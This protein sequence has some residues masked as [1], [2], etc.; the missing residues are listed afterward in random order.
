MRRPRPVALVILDGWGLDA[1]TEHNAVALARTPNVDGW[2]RSFPHCT[3]A[4]AGEA[5][6]LLE[7]QIGNSNVGHLNLGAGRIV[8]QDLTRIHRTIRTG[9]FYENP[10]L[11]AAVDRCAK[12]ASRAGGGSASGSPVL[13]LMG[14]VSDGGV[15][16]HIEHL[17]ALIDLAARRGV[18]RLCVHA[19]TDGRDVPPTGADAY[20][21]RVEEKLSR[22][23]I[24]A[25]ASVS[26]R[27]YA[28][29]RDHRWDRTRQAYDA[30]VLGEG[31]TAPS[32]ADAV[33]QAYARGETDEFIRPTVVTDAAGQPR[34]TIGPGDSV[35][36]FNFRADRGRQLSYALVR[37]EFDG[38]PR[39]RFVPVQ[40][41]TMAQYDEA[42]QVPVA[43]P[44]R[45]LKQTLGEVLAG[46]GLKQLR[47]AETEKYAHVTFFFNG[48][49]ERSF[50]GEDRC[51][52]PSPRVATYDLKPEMSAFEVTD[53]AVRRVGEGR[54]DFILVN[55][56]NPDMVGHTGDLR[57]AI[58]AVEAVDACCGRLV[59]AV[60]EA[61]G[62]ALVTADHG[63]AETM[64][65]AG[66]GQPHTAHTANPVPCVLVDPARRDFG[67]ADGILGNVAPTVLE[68]MGLDAPAEME[69]GS[70]LRAPGS[71]AGPPDPGAGNRFAPGPGPVGGPG[72]PGVRGL[73]EEGPC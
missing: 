16:S 13:H 53:E 8:Y 46:H 22:T 73:K 50:P 54:Y 4:A 25:V 33:R 20:L 47:I 48:G 37:E 2:R 1:R 18:S 57:A 71:P 5:V 55:Y 30:L 29:D 51:L 23:G 24:G 67:L 44:P 27:Y 58:R 28:M 35:V 10:V 63:N 70:L 15:H 17:L 41:V 26:G 62:A 19:F 6:G 14:L 68:L 59:A 11:L 39:R 32:A 45:Y 69:C 60:L 49:D 56:A 65:D 43:F 7:G 34:G 21:G 72:W 64:W 31:L 12:A 52:V 3:L 9:E 66:A 38:F 61:G 42:L 40:L 36:F